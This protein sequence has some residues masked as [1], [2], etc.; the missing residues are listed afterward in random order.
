MVVYGAKFGSYAVKVSAETFYG[1]SILLLTFGVVLMMQ[2]VEGEGNADC[3]KFSP[4]R[5]AER[6]AMSTAP[7]AVQAALHRSSSLLPQTSRLRIGSRLKILLSGGTRP[8][9]HE[10]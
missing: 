1:L 7:V 5:D 10:T 6:H 9:A 4:Y 2:K 3:D 8:L